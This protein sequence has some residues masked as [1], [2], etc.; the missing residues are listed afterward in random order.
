[1]SVTDLNREPAPFA[2]LPRR[3]P[4]SANGDNPASPSLPRRLPGA[5]EP[6]A[7]GGL[8]RRA[9]GGRSRRTGRH[10]SLHRISVA[11]DAPALVL[12][13]PGQGLETSGLADRIAE[14]AAESCSG[15]DIRIGY[16]SG[17]TDGL[18]HVL[19][20]SQPG[21]GHSD[22][23]RPR[24][25]RR[26]RR[27]RRERNTSDLARPQHEPRAVVVPLL[28]GPHPALDAAIAS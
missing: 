12:A 25:G 8:P 14:S 7:P 24:R 23:K 4:A 9:P 28:A 5:P 2:P 11:S 17:S 27:D 22:A 1:M 6:V 3:R 13:V 20:A 10:R 26:E 18:A 16:L 15:V 21:S 19:A